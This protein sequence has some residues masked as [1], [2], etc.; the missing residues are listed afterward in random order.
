MKFLDLEGL[1]YFATKLIEKLPS[2]VR[3]IINDIGFNKVNSSTTNGNILL[4]DV[5][6]KVYTHPNTHAASMI[7]GLATVATSGKYSDLTGQ[8]TIPTKTSQL[9]ND[10]G[11]KTTD[12]TY[13]VVSTTADGLAPKRDGSTTKFLRADGTWAVPPDNNTTY[14]LSSFGVTATAAELNYTDGVTSNIQTQ[15]NGKAASSH[16][17]DIYFDVTTARSASTVL[18]APNGS[19][20]SASFRKLVAADLPSHTHSYAPQY[21]YGT[22]AMTPG[23]STLATGI[24]YFQ[25]E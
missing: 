25:Y 5:E 8:P 6:T 1:G 19:A 4:D 7:T 13:S 16:T 20:G 12:T 22:A 2:I 18:A 3:E 10:S 11:F 9:T 14:T 23:T 15:L 24:L 21:T 17:H